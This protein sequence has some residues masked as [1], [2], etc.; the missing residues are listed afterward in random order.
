MEITLCVHH[1]LQ[2]MVPQSVASCLWRVPV[3]V[4]VKEHFEILLNEF[5]LM[6]R[7]WAGCCNTP[8]WLNEVP[9]AI[10]PFKT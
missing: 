5:L 1:V 2:H 7:V 9:S 8:V 10:S 4:S 6:G 3:P